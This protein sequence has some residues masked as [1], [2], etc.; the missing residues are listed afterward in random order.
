MAPTKVT[1]KSYVFSQLFHSGW[2]SVPWHQRQYDW[3]KESVEELL[4]DLESALEKD[5]DCYFLGAIMLVEKKAGYW[6][7]NDGQQRMVT[8]ALLCARL[9]RLFYEQGEQQLE[10][11]ALRILFDVKENTSVTLEHADN[12]KPRILPPIN[13]KTRFFL[14]LR[15]KDIGTNGKLTDAWRAIDQTITPMSI[16]KAKKFFDFI[17]NKVEVNC[18]YIPSTM[19]VNAVYETINC[20]G[21]RLDDLDLIRNYLYSWFNIDKDITRQDTVNGHLEDICTFFS[22]RKK[23]SEYMRCFMQ[24]K[25]GFIAEEKFYKTAKSMIDQ[26][27]KEN[28]SKSKTKQDYVFA[29]IEEMAKKDRMQLYKIVATPQPSDDWVRQFHVDC[30][31]DKAKRNLAVFLTEISTYSI[32]RPIIFAL[33]CHYLKPNNSRKK[34]AKRIHND[35]KKITSFVL[36]TAFVAPKFEPSRFDSTFADKAHAI[37]QMPSIFKF[38]CMKFLKEFDDHLD[39]IDDKKFIEKIKSLEMRNAK[40]AK[41][42]LLSLNAFFQTD[43]ALINERKCTLEHILPQGERHWPDWKEF[44]DTDPKDWVHRLGNLTILGGR[45]NKFSDKANKNFVAKKPIFVDSAVQISREL[46]SI[47]VWSPKNLKKRQIQLAKQATK[48]WEF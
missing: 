46:Q 33:L 35:I 13:D 30:G 43:G 44:A 15:D 27:T 34:V 4:E 2:F 9:C 18:L 41:R 19:D 23:A 14:M 42:F 3:G 11:F 17:I 24:C 20:R 12:Y 1:S 47:D 16:E 36:R 7:I 28:S 40:K 38:D 45:D 32:F 5:S 48:V 21:K 22:T 29:L 37:Y 39:I 10:G 31:H 25:Y 6:E 26:G 8:F